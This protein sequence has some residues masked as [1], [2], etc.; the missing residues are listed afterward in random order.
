MRSTIKSKKVQFVERSLLALKFI[1]KRYQYSNQII[2]Y[3]K[4]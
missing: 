3:Q 4:L 1:S 2:I